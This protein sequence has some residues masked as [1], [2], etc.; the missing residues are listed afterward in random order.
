MNPL[1]FPF[2]RIKSVYSQLYDECNSL[3][4]QKQSNP[5]EPVIPGSAFNVAFTELEKLKKEASVYNTDILAYNV[6]IYKKKESVETKTNLLELKK[7]L[8]LLYLSKKR[9]DSKVDQAC[10]DYQSEEN[11]KVGLETEK[12]NA[13]QKLDEYC[14]TILQNYEQSINDYLDLFNVGFSINNS[15]HIYSGGRPSAQYQICINETNLDLGDSQTPSGTPC[16]RTALSSGD[17]SALALAFFLAVLKQDQLIANKTIVFDDP[18]TSQD[19]FR[20]TCTQQLI[21]EFSQLAEQIIVLSHDPHFLKL[22]WDNNPKN[23]IKTIQ[24]ARTGGDIIINEWDIEADTQSTYYRDHSKLLI[25]YREKSGNLLDTVRSIR[26][27]LEAFYRAHFPSYFEPNEWLGDFIEK[28]R[29]TIPTESLHHAFKDLIE[30]EA[31]NEYSKKY[32]HDQNVNAAL[33]PISADELHGFIKR[34]LRL[35][36]GF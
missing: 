34:T 32:H 2:E 10:Q 15:H 13:K 29:N 20:R 9:F 4:Q 18:F 24:F 11:R 35:V 6:N 27:F 16:F 14:K 30:I 5:L 31:I 3:V 21:R 7:D 25:F 17:R 33:E 22:I 12:S 36:G 26:P 8:S 19:R 23:S 1:N 28:L